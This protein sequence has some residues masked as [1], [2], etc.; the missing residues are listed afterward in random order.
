MQTTTRLF[1]QFCIVNRPDS[2]SIGSLTLFSR[3][4]RNYSTE[5][6]IK[7][8]TE[9]FIEFKAN[10]PADLNKFFKEL[11]IYPNFI[12]QVE[13]DQLVSESEKALK[14]KKYQNTHFDHVIT[15]Y[16]ETEKS[17]WVR[18]FCDFR[19]FVL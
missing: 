14:K 16:R 5:Q 6:Q 18:I 19:K 1:R 15:G 4:R 8:Q 7:P 3:A 2:V 13:Q 12:T 9:D 17:N 10:K 11:Q